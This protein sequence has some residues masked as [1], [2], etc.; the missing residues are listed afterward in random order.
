[1]ADQPEAAPQAVPPQLPTQQVSHFTGAV[2]PTEI[3]I[4]VGQSRVSISAS[5]QGPVGSS[6]VEWLACLSMSATAATMLLQVLQR[7]IAVYE[8]KYGK[9]PQDPNFKIS[10]A[11]GR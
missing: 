2:N 8:E 9:I 1:M 4:A 7:S 3:L 11:Q 6:S 5:P 10:Q